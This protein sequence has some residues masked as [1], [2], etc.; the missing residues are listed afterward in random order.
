MAANDTTYEAFYQRAGF[1][2]PSF[3]G[4]RPVDS[5]ISRSIGQYWDGQVEY[6]E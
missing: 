4:G 5:L 3:S 6:I 2:E 1:L